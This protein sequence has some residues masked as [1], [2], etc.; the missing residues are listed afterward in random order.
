MHITT[1]NLPTD[2]VSGYSRAI[3]ASDF[4]TR[5]DDPRRDTWTVGKMRHAMNALGGRPV[6]ITV[7]KRTGMTLTG[8]AIVRTF[9]RFGGLDRVTVTS[10]YKDDAD[11]GVNYPLIDIGPAI[12]PLDTITAGN[13]PACKA[14][15]SWRA[16]VNR[17][18]EAV[19][20]VH[21]EA[22]GR[23]WGSWRGHCTGDGVLVRYEPLTGNPFYAD[24]WGTPWWGTYNLDGQISP[25]V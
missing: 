1:A 6:V 21:G 18:I 24:K 19:R 3:Q 25:G 16:E 14:H 4:S 20:A 23:A 12:V 13:D 5:V 22:Q 10:R 17:A 8:V 11:Q 15:E 2:T 9:T 7:D